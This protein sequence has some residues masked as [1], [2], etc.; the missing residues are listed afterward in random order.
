VRS[1]H[2]DAQV[3]EFTEILGWLLEAHKQNIVLQM[4]VSW[5]LGRLSSS[6]KTINKIDKYD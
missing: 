3:S 4:I 1:L 6:M 5:H 2:T